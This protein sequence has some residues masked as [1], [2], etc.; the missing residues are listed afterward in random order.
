MSFLSACSQEFE[1]ATVSTNHHLL[2]GK[3]AMSPPQN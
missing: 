1:I 3:L 2:A